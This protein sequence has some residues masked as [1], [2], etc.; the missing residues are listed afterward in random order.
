MA[1]PRTA[2]LVDDRRECQHKGHGGPHAHGGLDF[3]GDAKERTDAQELAEND[4]VDKYRA[5]EY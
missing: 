5:D 3:A 4:I 1:T 2:Q